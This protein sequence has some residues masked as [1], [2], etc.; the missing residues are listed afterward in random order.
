[1]IVPNALVELERITTN[2]EPLKQAAVMALAIGAYLEMLLEDEDP[3]EEGLSLKTLQQ[4]SAKAARLT[5]Q[6]R[7]V[8]RV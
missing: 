6:L 2:N 5:R 7:E 4:L 1:M 3:G 8:A